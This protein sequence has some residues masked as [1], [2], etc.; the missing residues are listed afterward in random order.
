MAIHEERLNKLPKDGILSELEEVNFS[1]ENQEID[2]EEESDSTPD[3]N[4]N[5]DEID[6][7]RG[8]I[9][10][11]EGEEFVYDENIEMTSFL[12]VNLDKKKESSLLLDEFGEQ[13][14]QK[15]QWKIGDNPLSEFTTE[16]LATMSFPTLFPDA[17]GDPTN[18]ATNRNIAENETKAFAPKIKDLIK[19]AENINGKWIYRFAAHPRFPYWSYNMLYRRRL[20]KQGSFF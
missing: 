9:G 14:V 12:P 20:S 4:I 19:F 18:H 16:F 7:D 3:D 11:Q 6:I 13:H 2:E 17:R 15:H 5:Y 8:P 1:S 10:C